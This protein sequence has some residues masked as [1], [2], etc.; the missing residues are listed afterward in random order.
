MIYAVEY[1]WYTNEWCSLG[2]LNEEKTYMSCMAKNEGKSLEQD[3]R[4]TILHEWNAFYDY[5][6][7]PNLAWYSIFIMLD[8]V[9]V[10]LL[11]KESKY[12]LFVEF[13]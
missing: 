9:C 2:M 8:N 11:F 1:V 6:L 5:I 3:D 4:C 12:Y 7:I 10:I 13:I